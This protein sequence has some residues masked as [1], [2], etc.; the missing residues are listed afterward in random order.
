M[1]V[2]YNKLFKM[3]IDKGMKKT[4]FAKEVGISAN[5]LAK[6]SRNETVSMEVIIR[7]CRALGC[8]VDDIMDIL[9]ET[10]VL[11]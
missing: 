4:E 7:I 11:G 5:T 9:P 6:L 1:D 8:S 2:S 3:L 10:R